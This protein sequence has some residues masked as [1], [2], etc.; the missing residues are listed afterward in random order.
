VILPFKINTATE[1]DRSPN[2]IQADFNGDGYGDIAFFDYYDGELIRIYSGSSNTLVQTS[3]TSN[4]SLTSRLAAGDFNGDG[5]TDL[6][7]SSDGSPTRRVIVL[8]SEGAGG[9]PSTDLSTDTPDWQTDGAD[10]LSIYGSSLATGDF[11]RDGYDDLAVGEKY[12]NDT[13][14]SVHVFHGS[15]TGLA[16]SPA[17]SLTGP[18][19]GSRFGDTAVAGDFNG[20]GYADLAVGAFALDFI[21]QDVTNCG[22]AAVYHGG[23]S[24]IAATP[25]W[26]Q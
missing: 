12:M 25:A 21:A 5:Y 9:I 13:P 6:A 11:N 1:G 24:G 23:A 8:L 3:V 20:D 2:F 15:G 26:A 22:Y 10:S 19:N 4:G 7:V 18:A 17:V 16:G 14:G